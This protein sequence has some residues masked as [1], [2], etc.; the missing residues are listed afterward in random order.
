MYLCTYPIVDYNIR[1]LAIFYALHSIVRFIYFRPQRASNTIGPLCLRP[2]R[3]WP[4]FPSIGQLAGPSISRAIFFRLQYIWNNPVSTFFQLY[5]DPVYF[6]LKRAEKRIYIGTP[7]PHFIVLFCPFQYIIA[8][9]RARRELLLG[10]L[11]VMP[12]SYILKHVVL[13]N[14]RKSSFRRG[15]YSLM[16]K[17]PFVNSGMHTTF[18]KL[19][20]QDLPI[21]GFASFW[22]WKQ[23]KHSPERQTAACPIYPNLFS[24]NLYRDDDKGKDNETIIRLITAL[25]K[26]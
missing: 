21:S 9:Y 14:R 7:I 12:N 17:S 24:Y 11:T 23:W 26:G 10:Y 25:Q 1:P 15:R 13:F 4:Q 18:M 16:Y 3:T 6:D 22:D 5:I 20:D 19:V 2:I 8:T